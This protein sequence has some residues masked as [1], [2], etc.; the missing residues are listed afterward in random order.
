VRRNIA[1]LYV[2]GVAVHDVDDRRLLVWDLRRR[3]RRKE[4]H[5]GKDEADDGLHKI[6]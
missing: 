6:L 5:Q 2:D 1:K 4:H 3:H